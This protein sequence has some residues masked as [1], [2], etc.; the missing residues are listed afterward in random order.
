M[1]E[2]RRDGS[3]RAAPDVSWS[4]SSSWRRSSSFPGRPA[5][6]PVTPDQFYGTWSDLLSPTPEAAR[7]ELDRIAAAGVGLV[8][9]Y[10]WWDRIERHPALRL[11]PHGPDGHRR[12]GPR[13]PDPA[14]AALPAG[15][16]LLEA[17]GIDLQR[18]CS[19]RRTPRPWPAS[20]RRWSHRYGPDGIV[21]VHAEPAVA[22]DVQHA[23]TLPIRAWEVWNEP[24]YPSWWKGG[25]RTPASTSTLLRG[26]VRR[27]QPGR[28]DSAEVVL[29]ALTNRASSSGAFLDQLYDLG[30]A[31]TSTRS[32]STPTPRTS[33]AW[34]PAS[35]GPAASRDRNGDGA[36]PIRVTEYGWAT[37][38]DGISPA[39]S[40]TEPCQAALLHA[41]TRRLVA[42]RAELNI[43]AIIQFQ[44]HDVPTTS[45]AWPH[46]TGVIRADD[47][48]KPSLGALTEAI[49]DRPPPAGLTPAQVCPA[50]RQPLDPRLAD[51][52]ATD[53]FTRSAAS[54][55]GSGEL[56]APGHSAA[57]PAAS[58]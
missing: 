9:Q 1:R 13:R 37:R 17:A 19:R 46:Y 3:V 57:R 22:A 55:W 45:T 16:L 25:A 34:S 43:R 54:E 5:P 15:L 58:R 6:A 21:L 51:S 20:P 10:V 52:V 29:G 38:G 36:A 8:R 2:D 30:A 56:G 31:P 41:A 28:P 24:D 26:R 23:R 39:W 47:S 27:H 44:W 12:H 7:V 33:P 11:E 4:W 53:T 48:P 42:L 32:P 50:E 40:T 49:A 14:D 35:A 18:A